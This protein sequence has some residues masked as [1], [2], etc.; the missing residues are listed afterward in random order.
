[1]ALVGARRDY[2]DRVVLLAGNRD[3]NKLRLVRELAAPPPRPIR[4]AGPPRTISTEPAGKPNR[5]LHSLNNEYDI[6]ISRAEAEEERLFLDKLID[7]APNAILVV[8][9]GR[10]LRP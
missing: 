10:M 5:W 3:L 8:D 2:G 4:N 6:G 7:S 1:M 9:G